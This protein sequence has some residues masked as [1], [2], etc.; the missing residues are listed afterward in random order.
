MMSEVTVD[1]GL[2]QAT[3]DLLSQD[4]YRCVQK[5]HLVKAKDLL[6]GVARSDRQRIA[7]KTFDGNAPLFFAAHQGHIHLVN[8]LLDECGADIEQ[9]G[10][11]EVVE[12]RTRH[13]VTPLWCAAVANQLEVVKTLIRHGADVNATSDTLSTPVRS[14]CYMTNIDVVKYLV[15]NGADI[16][17]PNMNG[18][19][20]LINSVQSV[21]LCRF[22]IEKKAD[23]NAQDNSG[24]L[25]LHYAIR[26]ERMETVKLLIKHNSDVFIKNDVGDDG[27]RTASLRGY[28]AILTFLIQCAKPSIICQ[29][30]SY[31]L[32]AANF[33]DEKNDILKAIQLWRL[34]LYMRE[35]H[36]MLL[37]RADTKAP[38]PAYKGLQEA[39]SLTELAEIETSPDAIYMHALMVRERL[40][41]PD[42]KDTVFGLMYRGAM[43]AD[44]H[45]YQRCV[46]LWKYAF[47][48]HHEK[49]EP[50]NHEGLYTLQALCKL[51]LEIDEE[52]QGGF[53]EEAVQYEDVLCVFDIVCQELDSVNGAQS[54]SVL[55]QMEDY[56]TMVRLLL[57]LIR[58][59]N[60]IASEEQ[61]A[62]SFRQKVYELLKRRLNI[63]DGKSLLHLAL[64][65]KTSHVAGE[66]YSEF[67][68]VDIVTL[69]LECGA[70]VN[71]A[72]SQGSMP[73]HYCSQLAR[74]RLLSVMDKSKIEAMSNV[75]LAK[76]AHADA[77]NK[78]GIIAGESL[79]SISYKFKMIDHITLKC[80]AAR[81]IKTHGIPYDGEVIESLHSF[82][83]IH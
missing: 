5:N 61:Q 35:S 4:L 36:D 8:Y 46:D 11:F 40:L 73:L 17:K 29:I 21:E 2:D 13:K 54:S 60:R 48:L 63:A 55:N 12:D 30:E 24:N 49:N 41:G 7:S 78:C 52:Y 53:T 18:G 56:Q 82:I 1:S 44:S 28:P 75:L 67:P 20:C 65:G 15:E 59:L 23:V 71:Q 58:L 38:V 80:L 3:I 6:K 39:I 33:V 47:Q 27:F 66:Y 83:E 77:R 74:N 76:G 64:E 70:D 34:A 69:L 37:T 62:S 31:E 79:S 22:L 10:V 14:A 25:A 42:H 81:F 50:L 32:M 16:H 19:T 9:R 68:C 45:R 57:H 51:F 43:Y 26:E 72:D